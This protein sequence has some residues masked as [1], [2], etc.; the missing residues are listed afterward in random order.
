M[1][2]LQGGAAPTAPASLLLTATTGRL[3]TSGSA[4]LAAPPGG[5]PSSGGDSNEGGTRPAPLNLPP[6]L[7]GAPLRRPSDL[8]GAPVYRAP[9]SPAEEAATCGLQQLLFTSLTVRLVDNLWCFPPSFCRRHCATGFLP[10]QH[11]RVTVACR[12]VYVSDDTRLE[13]S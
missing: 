13:G 6:L 5:V 11:V 3:P 1:K 12:A 9:P 4:P 2:D 10:D 7:L 8:F